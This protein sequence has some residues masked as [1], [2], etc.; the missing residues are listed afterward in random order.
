MDKNEELKNHGVRIMRTGMK[1]LG[2]FLV[3]LL[4]MG[5]EDIARAYA[6]VLFDAFQISSP[7]TV[8]VDREAWIEEVMEVAK[9]KA[10]EASAAAVLPIMN[11]VNLVNELEVL[12]AVGGGET[13]EGKVF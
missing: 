12:T 9:D 8:P 7:E 11:I 5:R 3:A 6:N 1:E 13:R 10:D 4:L 2:R